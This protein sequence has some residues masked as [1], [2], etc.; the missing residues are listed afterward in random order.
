MQTVEAYLA[1]EAASERCGAGPPAD[2]GLRGRFY[3]AWGCYGH[4]VAL[5]VAA[6]AAGVLSL[7]IAVAEATIPE[8]LPNA[9]LVSWAVRAAAARSAL[10][11]QVLTLAFLSYLVGCA[12]YSVY[13]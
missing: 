3:W 10:G 1:A 11:S 8:N 12:Y 9:S 2:A 4:A 7:A 6:V 5:R 13:R